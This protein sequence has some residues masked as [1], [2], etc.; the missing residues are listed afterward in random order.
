[1]L[2]AVIYTQHTRFTWNDV[3]GFVIRF[4]VRQ[5]SD[6]RICSAD[7][8][9]LS[10]SLKSEGHLEASRLLTAHEKLDIKLKTI[11]SMSMAYWTVSKITNLSLLPKCFTWFYLTVS[12]RCF[13]GRWIR[14]V[15]AAIKWFELCGS[16]IASLECL[17]V[18]RIT[19][20]H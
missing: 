9:S 13:D 6:L 1:M 5:P 15:A 17:E 16:W 12:V 18:Y 7:V 20:L 8:Y 3:P 11:W 2:Y 14:R 4:F 10:G 19:V